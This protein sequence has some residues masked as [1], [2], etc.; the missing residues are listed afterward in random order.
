MLRFYGKKYFIFLFQIKLNVSTIPSGNIEIPL[1]C[2]IK[3]R[4][5]Q[6]SLI[7]VNPNIEVLAPFILEYITLRLINNV[8]HNH[9]NSNTLIVPWLLAARIMGEDCLQQTAET[10]SLVVSPSLRSRSNNDLTESNLKLNNGLL[11]PL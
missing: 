11:K 1:L 4:G 3:V 5:C 9:T 8:D 7:Y 2:Y 6:T 10:N